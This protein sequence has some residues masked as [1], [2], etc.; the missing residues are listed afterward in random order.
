M[1][2]GCF[3]KIIISNYNGAN[4]IERCVKSVLDQK[5]ADFKII[6]VDDL[7]T[8]GSDMTCEK[9][10][11]ENPDRIIFKK[12]SSKGYAGRCRNIGLE[13]DVGSKYTWIIDGDDWLHNGNTL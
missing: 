13:T 7:S 4:C 3:F 2:I 6:I 8:D 5:F 1:N 11:A 12:V 9:L 10:A